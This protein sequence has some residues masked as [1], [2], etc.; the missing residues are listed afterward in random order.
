MNENNAMRR[1]Y[2]A[3]NYYGS[4]TATGFAN[5]WFVLAFSTRV[6]RDHYVQESGAL[7]CRAIR[8]EEVSR[9]VMRRPE[10]FTRQRYALV[11]APNT[12]PGCIGEVSVCE[13]DCPQYIHDFSGDV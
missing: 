9:Y 10:P 4:P 8:R 11:T 7:P 5:T 12:I 3:N 1:Y 6:A 13:P 2:A